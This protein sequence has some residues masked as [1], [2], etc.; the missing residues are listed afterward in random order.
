MSISHSEDFWYPDGNVTLKVDGVYFKLF[1][2]RL[3]RH[4]HYFKTF[5]NQ[6]NKYCVRGREP[7]WIVPD[8][9]YLDFHRLLEYLEVPLCV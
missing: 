4:C 8:V 3:E 9:K 5:F 6:P 2:S 7:H 1:R